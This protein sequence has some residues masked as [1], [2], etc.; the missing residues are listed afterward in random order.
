MIIIEKLKRK[1][2]GAV[3]RERGGGRGGRERKMCSV[4]DVVAQKQLSLL[5]VTNY[6]FLALDSGNVS[7]LTLLGLSAALLEFDIIDHCIV[8]NRFQHMYGFSGTALSRFSSY[9]TNRTVSHR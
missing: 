8:L 4:G 7:L 6:I 5:K 3:S 9:L 1:G 2:V